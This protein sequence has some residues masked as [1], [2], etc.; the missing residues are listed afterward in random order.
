M[1]FITMTDSQKALVQQLRDT[2]LERFGSITQ[3]C[4]TYQLR[5]QT[6]IRFLNGTMVKWDS[7]LYEALRDM[8]EAPVKMNAEIILFDQV[9]RKCFGSYEVFC[10][11]A[12]IRMV[13]LNKLMRLEFPEQSKQFI[14][15]SWLAYSKWLHEQERV[16]PDHISMAPAKY[17]R[18]EMRR[19]KL[20]GGYSAATW[21]KLKN[22]FRQS[23]ESIEDFQN[24]I[25]K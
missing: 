20:L 10:K 16:F 3:L 15:I 4:R 13:T 1:L 18:Q 25:Q 7:R 22:S 5:D 17:L 14:R 6:V 8:A 11:V 9:I 12:K 23:G 24:R 19:E 2:V 21:M